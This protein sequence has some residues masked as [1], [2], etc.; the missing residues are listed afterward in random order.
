MIDKTKEYFLDAY[1]KG[2]DHY[3]T[4]VPEKEKELKRFIKIIKKSIRKPKLLDIGC[5]NGKYTILAAKEGIDSYGIDI[6]PI[7]IRKAK[8]E[9]TK[10]KVKVSFRVG[11]ALNMPYPENYFDAAIDFCCFTHFYTIKWNRYFKEVTRILKPGGYFLFSVWS[12]NSAMLSEVNFDPKTSKRNWS[13]SRTENVAG[14]LFSYY[15]TKKKLVSLLKRKGFKIFSIR[16]I[17]LHSYSNIMPGSKL[18]LW[19][20]YCKKEN[21]LNYF[22]K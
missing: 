5:G 18:R 7:A 15:F 12:K 14:R 3:W 8:K 20:A 4:S 6:S 13:L 2:V 17:L 1:K 10:Q 9:A 11:D 22:G 21:I 16:E 19:F